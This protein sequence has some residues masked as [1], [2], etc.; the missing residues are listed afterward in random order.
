M[1]IVYAGEL[2]TLEVA[3]AISFLIKYSLN[4]F[5]CPVTRIQGDEN[6]GPVPKNFIV[7]NI[8]C[9]CNIGPHTLLLQMVLGIPLHSVSHPHNWVN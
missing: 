3:Q 4:A 2:L 8:V 9:V 5:P 7:V 1:N 6:I